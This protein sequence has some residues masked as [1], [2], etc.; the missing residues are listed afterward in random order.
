MRIKTIIKKTITVF[1]V[2]ITLLG[3][4]FAQPSEEVCAESGGWKLVDATAYYD[5]YGYGYG[6]T[7]QPLVE[8]LT[9]AGRPE[10]LGKTAYIYDLDKNLIGIYEF[11]DTGYGQAT[12]YG[13]SRILKGKTKG[14]IEVGQ[15]IDIYMT[16]YA[17]C[18]AWGRQK[19]YL[20]IVEAVG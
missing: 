18:K 7:G 11:R 3:L 8:G 12:G 1:V 2:C 17:K 16:T 10:D 4:A 5:V 19:V 15:C 6:A 20:R 13:S 9:I 14:T